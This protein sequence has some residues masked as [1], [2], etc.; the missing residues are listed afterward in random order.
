MPAFQEILS[1]FDLAARQA[2]NQNSSAVSKV[3]HVP[4]LIHFGKR[5]HITITVQQYFVDVFTSNL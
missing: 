3:V 2:P 4:H 1:L 5:K